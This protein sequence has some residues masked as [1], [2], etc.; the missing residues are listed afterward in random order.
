MC[1]RS[2]CFYRGN[3]F[4]KLNGPLTIIVKSL[5]CFQIIASAAG[6]I[7]I[8][9]F[10]F[11]KYSIETIICRNADDKLTY[12]ST[13]YLCLITF[14]F[15]CNSSTVV[16]VLSTHSVC[17]TFSISLACYDVVLTRRNSRSQ[18]VSSTLKRSFVGCLSN[19]NQVGTYL[20]C[21][22]IKAKFQVSLTLGT[23][24]RSNNIIKVIIVIEICQNPIVFSSCCTIR[25]N[26]F[27]L[28]SFGVN[29]LISN[30][31]HAITTVSIHLSRSRSNRN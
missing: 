9:T 11:I 16:G 26:P 22:S 29:I 23:I 31:N 27:N 13:T 24:V 19:G 7:Q 1:I 20:V 17:I 3:T 25:L 10:C 5:L 12:I 15:Y 21:L 30:D 14:Y 28:N 8:A 2:L 6:C 18:R 4:G